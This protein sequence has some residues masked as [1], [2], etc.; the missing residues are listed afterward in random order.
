M[1]LSGRADGTGSPITRLT[2]QLD[3]GTVTPIAFD[4]A[5]GRF[6]Q[7]ARLVAPGDRISHALRHG[8]MPAD[9][10]RA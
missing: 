10:K 3:A 7:V 1:L 8:G 6:D 5:T 4:S 2:Y 9:R